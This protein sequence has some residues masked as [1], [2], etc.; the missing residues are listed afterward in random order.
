[1]KGTWTTT[2][3]GGGG[4][5][6]TVLAAIVVALVL[7]AVL[8]PVVRAAVSLLETAAIVAG[9]LL[10]LGIV[11]GVVLVVIRLHRGYT[12]IP[13]RSRPV[14]SAEVLSGHV[15]SQRAV[16]A[17]TDRVAIG[18]DDRPEVHNHFHVHLSGVSAEADA[19]AVRALREGS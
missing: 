15:R 5:A 14:M 10:G 3:S 1:M 13:S 18:R 11:G 17:D 9:V 12:A 8:G 7:V 4:G 2:D 6:G 16:T 19:A